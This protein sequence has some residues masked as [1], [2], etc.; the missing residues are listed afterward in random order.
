[1]LITDPIYTANMNPQQRAWFYAEYEQARKDEAI[2]VLLA[3]FLGCF[4]LHHFY[5]R[6]NGLGVLYLLFFWTGLTAILGF[7]ECFLM[8]GRVRDYNAA[9]ATYIASN[10]LATPVGYSAAV[11][12][13][14]VCGVA[15]EPGAAFCTHCGTAVVPPA[16]A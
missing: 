7:I 3:L 14:P 11:P 12:R 2:G 16:T 1:M 9:Q 4:G 13:C 5:L 6:R 10:I 15:S 8:P